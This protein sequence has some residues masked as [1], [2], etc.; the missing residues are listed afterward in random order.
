MDNVRF[1]ACLQ[2]CTTWLWRPGTGTPSCYAVM[3][4]LWP[5]GMMV[6]DNAKSQV[7]SCWMIADYL[8]ISNILQRKLQIIV[9]RL[10]DGNKLAIPEMEVWM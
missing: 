8:W 6:K 1:L 4:V 9:E 5:S 10:I 3:D 2:T 7:D